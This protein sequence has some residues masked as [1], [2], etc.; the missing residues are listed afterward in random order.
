MIALTLWRP[1]DEP[2]CSGAK[3]IENRPNPPP[4]KLLGEY[5]A[6][7]AGKKYDS[8][9]ATAIRA[10][11]YRLLG[12][13]GTWTRNRIGCIVGVARIAGWLDRRPQAMSWPAN[14]TIDQKLLQHYGIP[15]RDRI[16]RMAD[17][18]WWSGP[19]GILLVDARQIVTPL[20]RRGYQGW[21]TLDDGDER[22]VR[23]LAGLPARAA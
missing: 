20:R 16:I 17:N 8:A 13:D 19:V 5:V 2:V 3:P 9:G 22:V 18:P 23:S 12:D 7:H 21:W 15:L 11:G 6:I 4:R 14:A 1:W 10:R